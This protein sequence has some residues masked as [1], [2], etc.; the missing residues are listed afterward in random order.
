MSEVR[1]FSFHRVQDGPRGPQDGLGGPQEGSKTAHGGPRT[2]QEAP[3]TALE[4]PKTGPR[5]APE[6]KTPLELRAFG[7]ERHQETPRGPPEHPKTLQE[8]FQ[9]SPKKPKLCHS[10][11]KTYIFRVFAS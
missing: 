3:K 5:G 4:S 10:Y 7:P 9:E 6:K 8:A 2:A 1:L 11:G